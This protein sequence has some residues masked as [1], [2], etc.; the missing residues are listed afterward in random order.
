MQLFLASQN[1]RTFH[2]YFHP[3]VGFKAV[4][5]KMLV[6]NV[7]VFQFF[8]KPNRFSWRSWSS[9]CF[10]RSEFHTGNWWNVIPLSWSFS[11]VLLQSG[12]EHARRHFQF[13]NCT[14]KKKWDQPKSYVL[15]IGQLHLSF[16]PIS[17][18]TEWRDEYAA[19]LL[20]AIQDGGARWWIFGLLWRG[21]SLG[22]DAVWK[23]KQR[24]VTQLSVVFSLV[25][26]KNI[27]FLEWPPSMS[28]GTSWQR[29]VNLAFRVSIFV[30][31]P[32][33]PDFWGTSQ[34]DVPWKQ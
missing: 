34:P 18:W 11:D 7:D 19:R 28:I 24:S 15:E 32:A 1:T 30:P 26:T 10:A 2:R 22:S 17:S 5:I 4:S 23:L 12:T 3:G 25:S 20:S 33:L 21:I 9:H 31:K 16:T 6:K 29:L 13:N 8:G 14:A 27:H